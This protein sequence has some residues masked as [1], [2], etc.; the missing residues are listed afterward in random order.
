MAEEMLIQKFV[1]DELRKLVAWL[2]KMDSLEVF[3]EPVTKRYPDFAREYRSKIK[4]PMDF[5]TMSDNIAKG[6]YKFFEL[7]SKFV[8]HFMLMCHNCM[9]FN[10]GP[11]NTF[12]KLGEDFLDAGLQIIEPIV[13][14]LL[15]NCELCK[16]GKIPASKINQGV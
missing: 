15:K 11:D 4:E 12:H 5:R 2:I 9:E 14:V 6:E 16:Q 1:N 8:R 10:N 7:E 3:L 13:E